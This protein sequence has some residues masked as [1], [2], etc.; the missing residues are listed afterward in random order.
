MKKVVLLI[1]TMA[2]LM[3]P[4]FAQDGSPPSAKPIDEIVIPEL[5]ATKLENLQLKL[6][7]AMDR[8][9]RAQENANVARREINQKFS[10]ILKSLGIDEPQRWALDLPGRKLTKQPLPESAEKPADKPTPPR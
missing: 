6:Q 5:E 4:L 8:L 7:I 10:G 2:V 3:V 1:L 9:Q